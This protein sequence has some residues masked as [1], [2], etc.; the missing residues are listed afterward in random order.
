MGVSAQ[1]RL[2]ERW[3]KFSN[4]QVYIS[5]CILTI[6]YFLSKE[7]L[8]S[9]LFSAWSHNFCKTRFWL[10][11]LRPSNGLFWSSSSEYA[12][13]KNN[14]FRIFNVYTSNA[15]RRGRARSADFA[16]QCLS[17]QEKKLRNTDL[18]TA[19]SQRDVVKCRTHGHSCNPDP[20]ECWARLIFFGS[21]HACTL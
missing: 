7:E 5:N 9:F 15:R 21:W 1:C 10:F 14:I 2:V 4:V 18:A 13:K 11:A 17:L 3:G 20:K 6:L 12:G 8:F 16:F 19:S